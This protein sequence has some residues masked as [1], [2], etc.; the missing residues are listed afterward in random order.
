MYV[1]VCKY[2]YMHAHTHEMCVLEQK[3]KDSEVAKDLIRQDFE[4]EK[5]LVAMCMIWYIHTYICVFVCVY[6]CVYI[7]MCVCVCIYIYI[8]IYIHI[9]GVEARV[10]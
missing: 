4:H 1:D 8:Y 9:A 10:E 3:L 2:A 5:V 7:Y 6:V